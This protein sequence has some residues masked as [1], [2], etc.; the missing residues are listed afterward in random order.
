MR[1]GFWREDKRVNWAGEEADDDMQADH[2]IKIHINN[3][4]LPPERSSKPNRKIFKRSQ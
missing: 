2:E 4:E 3:K 1:E